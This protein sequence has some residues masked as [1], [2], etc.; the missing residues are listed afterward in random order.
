MKVN[1]IKIYD[2][3]KELTLLFDLECNL[4]TALSAS[5]Y[6]INQT[7]ESERTSVFMVQPWNQELSVFAS[8][9][10]VKDEI[11]IPKSSGV[12]GWVFKHRKPL[13]V[14]NAY[15]DSRFYK[16]V[17]EM[18]G[19]YTLNMICSPLIDNKNRCLGTLQSINKK[20][21][22]FSHNNL[23]LLNLIADMMAVAI[24]NNRCYN[25]NLVTS[26]ARKKCIDQVLG[27]IDNVFDRKQAYCT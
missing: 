2:L 17:D 7:L 1:M 5:I 16:G 19:Y 23:K 24:N 6:F 21:G 3:L 20:G 4:D 26:Q 22:E 15:N 8:L 25:E 9:D 27:N 11:R 14:N 10:L 12:T 18:T 13:I